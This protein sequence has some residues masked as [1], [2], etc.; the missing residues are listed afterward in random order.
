MYKHV[1][2]MSL[3]RDIED[4]EGYIYIYIFRGIQGI[5][6]LIKDILSYKMICNSAYEKCNSIRDLITGVSFSYDLFALGTFENSQG[7]KSSILD[8]Q[9]S[10]SG[11]P[12]GPY[13]SCDIYIYYIIYIYIIIYLYIYMPGFS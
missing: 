1:N 5:L 12:F 4:I 13:Q 11:K 7:H 10:H 8:L 9:G 6:C 2:G 3:L